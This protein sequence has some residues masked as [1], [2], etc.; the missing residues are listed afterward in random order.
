MPYLPNNE[1]EE[2][3]AEIEAVYP[4]KAYEVFRLDRALE[5]TSAVFG[6]ARWPAPTYVTASIGETG[7]L[8]ARLDQEGLVR[9]GDI[10]RDPDDGRIWFVRDPLSW[11]SPLPKVVA[12][13]EN[14]PDNFVPKALRI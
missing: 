7:R 1:I 14:V 4:P 3:W 11:D 5:D 12:T 10:L 13:V 6:V 2:L 8:K 9:A